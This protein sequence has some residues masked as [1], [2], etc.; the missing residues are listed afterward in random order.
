MR[1]LSYVFLKVIQ[2][3]CRVSLSSH[4]YFFMI[5]FA[6][7]IFVFDKAFA[8][9]KGVDQVEN[10]T[11]QNVESSSSVNR[12]LTRTITSYYLENGKF[13][14]AIQY[15]NDHLQSDQE[16]A[17]GWRLLGLVNFRVKQWQEAELAFKHAV[18]LTVGIEKGTNL[19][20]LANT[21]SMSSDSGGLAQT[22]K[23]LRKI[24][25]FKKAAEFASDY[26]SQGK[27]LP[28]L[29]IDE[30]QMDVEQKTS[31][32]Q[33]SG[34]RLVANLTSGFD[35]N[36][37][38]LSDP[39]IIPGMTASS[40]FMRPLA[41]V[42]QP[43]NFSDNLVMLNGM[44][45]YNRNFSKDARTFD[46]VNTSIGLDYR[47]TSPLAVDLGLATYLS[48][49]LTWLN[50][51]GMKLLSVGETLGL[52]GV[53]FRG[54]DWSFH[55]NLP[56]NNLRYPHPTNPDPE[57]DADGVEFS[58][59]LSHRHSIFATNLSE[60]FTF[61]KKFT[62]GSFT[63]SNTYIGALGLLK[64]VIPYRLS[65]E[66]NL[67]ISKALYPLSDPKR[68]DL[69]YAGDLDFNL[70]LKE[71][72]TALRFSIAHSQNHSTIEAGNYHKNIFSLGVTYEAF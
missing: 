10:K 26:G 28:K 17:E 25:G 70:S 12:E 21:Q 27:N 60:T 23:E 20:Y 11:D 39:S 67:N 42:Q 41:Q 44:A 24:P 16:D 5:L 33:Q 14:E 38:L 37:L 40:W 2:R 13:N 52:R 30:S 32:D 59:S 34:T 72:K 61:S 43:L 65:L 46:N 62:K 53:P 29:E 54:K 57:F 66:A 1:V 7:Q 35:T 63:R 9:N 56:I 69:T 51:D 55:F 8:Q 6:L 49:E 48:S 19:Y 31:L 18:K 15:L 47:M 68:T 58:P 22:V 50:S 4:L 45:F 64:E 71:I 36:V 3:L